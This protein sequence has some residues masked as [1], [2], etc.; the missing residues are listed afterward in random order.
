MLVVPHDVIQQI[1]NISNM[2]KLHKSL[3]PSMHA[4]EN[5]LIKYQYAYIKTRTVVYL[6]NIEYNT[7]GVQD[8]EI[9]DTRG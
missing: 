5:V 1:I 7:G 4:K 2:D 6:R 8:K 3:T 9:S